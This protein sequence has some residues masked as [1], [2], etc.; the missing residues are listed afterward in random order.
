MRDKMNKYRIMNKLCKYLNYSSLKI[1]FDV[2]TKKTFVS[3]QHSK[4]R[5][6]T[7]YVIS[8]IMFYIINYYRSGCG[9]FVM[10]CLHFKLGTCDIVTRSRSLCT[11]YNILHIIFQCTV[12]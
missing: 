7:N 4:R 12:K 9:L 1:F 11:S 10:C 2:G 8:L 6:D 3:I 5:S